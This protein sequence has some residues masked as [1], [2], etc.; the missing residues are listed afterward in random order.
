MEIW[1]ERMGRDMFGV[2]GRMVGRDGDV[3][4]AGCVRGSG[5]VGDCDG[6]R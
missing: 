5:G 3:V 2:A 1:G 4:R 6:G